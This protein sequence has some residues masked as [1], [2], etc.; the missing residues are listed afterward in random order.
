M[1]LYNCHRVLIAAVILF[2][3]GFS[4]S[5]FR[6]Y[7][8]GYDTVQLIMLIGSI[9]VTASLIGYII[10]FNKNLTVPRTLLAIGFQCESCGMNLRKSIATANRCSQC[11]AAPHGLP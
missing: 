3:L 5:C 11:G 6:N 8:R 2:E 10:Y 4:L 9:A 7:S 1:A